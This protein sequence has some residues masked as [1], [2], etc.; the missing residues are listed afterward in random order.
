MHLQLIK[1]PDLI[2]SLFYAIYSITNTIHNYAL[3][4][5]YLLFFVLAILLGP[6]FGR[7][8]YWFALRSLPFFLPISA[9]S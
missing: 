9:H 4:V 7:S 5:N 3:M 8:S 1:L 2:M 6:F